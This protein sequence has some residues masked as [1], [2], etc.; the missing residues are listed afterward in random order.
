MAV[1]TMATPGSIARG[2]RRRPI[3]DSFYSLAGR[4]KFTGFS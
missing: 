3:W 4:H 1:I 2:E